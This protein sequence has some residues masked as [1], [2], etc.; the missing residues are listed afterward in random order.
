[1][2]RDRH[3]KQT[4]TG[5]ERN[6]E[7]ARDYYSKDNRFTSVYIIYIT[8]SLS[9]YMQK[10]HVLEER[11]KT[12]E[13]IYKDSESGFIYLLAVCSWMKHLTS[14]ILSPPLKMKTIFI[15]WGSCKI[16]M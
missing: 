8:Q 11:G 16:Q 7:R 9:A 13:S 14:L 2:N 10:L 6:N 12:L 3:V 4:K 1:M 15:S 5:N